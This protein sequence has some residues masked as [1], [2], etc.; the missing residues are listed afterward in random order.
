MEIQLLFVGK[1]KKKYLLDELEAYK[2]KIL[3]FIKFSFI[4]I[5]ETKTSKKNN[6]KQL[7]EKE[8]ELVIKKI[9]SNDIV[10]I[11]DERG[12]LL[13]SIDFANEIKGY[14]N[15]GKKRVIFIIGGAYGLSNKFFENFPIRIALSKMTFSHQMIRLFFC[16]Q[17]YRAFTIINNHPYHNN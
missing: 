9:K 1:T 8:Y 11:L 15:T 13:S 4:S 7:K 12:K 2:K 6:I 3:H 14:M 5:E 16:E 17:L 10:I